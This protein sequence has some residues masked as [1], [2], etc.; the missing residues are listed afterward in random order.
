[1]DFCGDLRMGTVKKLV[2]VL[3]NSLLPWKMAKND[4]I[5]ET[6]IMPTIPMLIIFRKKFKFKNLKQKYKLIGVQVKVPL[7]AINIYSAMF[8]FVKA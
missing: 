8:V 1:M 3:T 5:I 2:S 7:I 6:V 4:Q